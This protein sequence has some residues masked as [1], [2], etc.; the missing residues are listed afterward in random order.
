MGRGRLRAPATGLNAAAVVAGL[1]PPEELLEIGFERSNVVMMNEAHDGL[2][3]CVRTRVIG[4]RLLPVADRLGVRHLAMEALSDQDLTDKANRERRLPQSGGYLGQ[5][6]M[7][8]FIQDA[9]DLGWTLVG[10]EADMEAAPGSDLTSAEVTRWRQLQ[11]AHNLAAALPHAPL[12][13]WC[14]WSHLSKTT[15]DSA[16]P[17][18]ARHFW[19]LT[20][21]EPFALDQT[22]TV[23]PAVAAVW[24]ER[25][26]S[27][28]EVLGGTGGFLP[29]D[30]PPGWLYCWG[31]AFLLSV[32]NDL[33]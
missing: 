3:R 4:R 10:Y 12:L 26:R 28:L 6:E 20:G 17:M 29:E 25:F 2:R 21:V 7:R 18:M 22:F 15:P 1:R 30:K 13:V 23:A 5:S 9:L 27:E 16:G 33:E 32:D 8:A 24:V 31:D 19:D 14:G 11:Q